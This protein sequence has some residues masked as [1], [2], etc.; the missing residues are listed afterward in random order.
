[1]KKILTIALFTICGISN[2][3]LNPSL[4]NALTQPFYDNSTAI[5]TDSFVHTSIAASNASVVLSGITG[6]TYNTASLGSGALLVYGSSAGVVTSIVT[7]AAAGTG[8]AVGDIIALAAG[9]HDAQILVTAVSSGGI[10]AA[11][12]IYGGTGYA[13]YGGANAVSAL[14]FFPDIVTFT[15]ALTSNVTFVLPAMGRQLGSKQYI[16][17]NNTTGAYTGTV[18]LTNG[19]GGT[20]GTCAVVPQGTANSAATLLETDGTTGIWLVSQVAQTVSGSAQP[21]ITSVGTLTGLAVSSSGGSVTFGQSGYQNVPL[22]VYGGITAGTSAS[23]TSIITA[24]NNGLTGNSQLALA[25]SAAS[26]QTWS[27]IVGGNNSQGLSG[28]GISEGN[29]SIR[30][31]SNIVGVFQKTSGWF[32]VGGTMPTSLLTVAPSSGNATITIGN[33]S[34]TGNNSLN[35]IA[36]GASNTASLNLSAVPAISQNTITGTTLDIGSDGTNTNFQY[37]NLRANAA[38]VAQ[39]TPSGVA[40]TGTLSATGSLKHVQQEI[41][42]SYTYNTPTTGQTVTL[43]SGTETAII[44][45]SGMLAALTVT[46]PSCTSGYDG[47]IARFGIEQIITALTVNTTSGSVVGAAAAS[48]AGQG[49]AYICRGALTTWFRIN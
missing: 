20:M 23:G 44:N 31:G 7:I 40:I 22:T 18:C 17:N 33:T 21:N 4:S 15:G 24:T 41:D 27:L 47:S 29:L 46:L 37:L 49:Q 28:A 48:T 36:S 25:N 42:A 9:N 1:M 45:P 34:V 12:P 38:T 19:A 43:A 5:A 3:A 13:I 6:G 39:I 11:A 14:L 26:G 16:V 2:A 10:T 35:I 32:G 30:N 8:Y